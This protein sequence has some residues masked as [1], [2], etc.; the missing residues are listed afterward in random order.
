MVLTNQS[1]R[2]QCN[3]LPLYTE[4][5]YLSTIPSS[6]NFVLTVTGARGPSTVIPDLFQSETPKVH[7]FCV[8]PANRYATSLIPLIQ[9][10]A[11]LVLVTPSSLSSKISWDFSFIFFLESY[12]F[13][14]PCITL[15]PPQYDIITCYNKFAWWDNRL[16]RAYALS[17][18]PYNSQLRDEE[19]LK[20]DPFFWVCCICSTFRLSV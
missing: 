16:L 19:S 10:L 5:R 17:G 20:W 15:H 6:L 2:R 12:V 18:W 7:N 1:Y 8:K 14:N 9:I 3:F 4:I 13:S 11:L